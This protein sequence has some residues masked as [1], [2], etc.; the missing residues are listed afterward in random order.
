MFSTNSDPEPLSGKD[1]N[2]FAYRTL[3][4]RL[5]VIITKVIDLLCRQRK[6]FPILLS[7]EK[8]QYT[9]AIEETKALIEELA[10][11]KYELQTNKPL[12]LLSTS[13][14]S[15]D[16]EQWNQYLLKHKTNNDS[17]EV[18]WFNVSWLYAECYFYRRMWETFQ[19]SAHYRQFDQFYLIKQES[20]LQLLPFADKLA[21]HLLQVKE[22]DL[23]Q[24]HFHF[25]LM[26]SLWGNRCDLSIS[27]GE[28]GNGS[29]NVDF[30]ELNSKIL[31]ND[32]NL[33]WNYV[34][35][36]NQHVENQIIIDVV[37]DNSGYELF[38]DFCL[39]EYL[40]Q[41]GMIPKDRSLVRFHVKKMP[42]FVSDTLSKDIDWLL[43]TITNDEKNE[44]FSKLKLIV[45]ENFR[46][47]FNRK[48]WLIVEND[49]WTLPHDFSDMKECDPNLYENFCNSN[50]VLFKGDLNYRKLVGDLKW[51][52]STDFNESLRKF[53][54]TTAICSLRT[55]K[56]DV[57]VGISD[58]KI[59]NEIE[60]SFPTNWM[61]TG[62][63]AVI[64]FLNNKP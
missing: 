55:I 47:N 50:F 27:C 35:I 36:L 4:E 41:S 6:Q 29:I 37:L 5:P 16:T 49:F 3:A 53:R 62:E 21:S 56:A 31:V 28:K 58:K 18:T 63:Y 24:D 12:K 43:Y 51:N 1:K 48:L 33:L 13:Y 11:L 14:G 57:V 23:N 34:K 45:N 22:S 25:Y 9:E 26:N 60:K 52:L 2:S 7:I 59:L 20:F 42:W 39:I 30:Q 44:I 38:T 10:R 17:Q 15:S 54:P 46:Q 40:H 64:H 8:D 61:E 19:L 32:F